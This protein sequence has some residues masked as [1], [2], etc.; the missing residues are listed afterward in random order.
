MY[1][2]TKSP[3][4]LNGLE[5]YIFKYLIKNFVKKLVSLIG[6]E[7]YILLSYNPLMY[8]HVYPKV[9]VIGWYSVVCQVGS[10]G[11]LLS[12]KLLFTTTYS[13][14]SRA[15]F[16]QITIYYYIYIVPYFLE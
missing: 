16:L 4:S 15:A 1:I 9:M 6:L 10:L 8:V 14:S 2:N 11:G 12:Y 5:K 7:K 13:V 3:S